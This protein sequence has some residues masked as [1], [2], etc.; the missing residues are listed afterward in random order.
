[1]IEVTVKVTPDCEE[2]LTRLPRG[3]EYEL[4]D[5]EYDDD[6]SGTVTFVIHDID[7]LTSGMEHALDTN[8]GVIKYTVNRN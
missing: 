4:T 3:Y 8:D 6:G 1:M 2:L 7:D 5:E